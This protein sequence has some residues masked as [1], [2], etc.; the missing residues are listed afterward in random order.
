MKSPIVADST[1]LIGLERIGQIELLPALFE[2]VF[3]PPEVA[4][5]FGVS[6]AWL[7]V[8]NPSDESL[9]QSLKLLI[10]Q[11]EA[12]ASLWLMKTVGRF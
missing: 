8:E 4:R 6:L 9:I 1:C 10:D 2:S 3:I 11:G 5:E 7:R 12:E